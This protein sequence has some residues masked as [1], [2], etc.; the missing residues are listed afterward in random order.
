MVLGNNG[1]IMNPEEETVTANVADLFCT[2]FF[3]RDFLDKTEI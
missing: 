3:R 2:L 1:P